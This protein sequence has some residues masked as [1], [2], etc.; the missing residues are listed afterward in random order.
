MAKGTPSRDHRR[1]V[2]RLQDHEIRSAGPDFATSQ[3]LIPEIM[4]Q[5]TAMLAPSL[6][7]LFEALATPAAIL[8]ADPVKIDQ[9][10]SG[11]ADHRR[12]SDL[13]TRVMPPSTARDT[14]MPTKRSRV[15]L[16]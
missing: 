12:K 4:P 15:L 8:N 2:A 5:P 11:R 10:T 9:N 7:S 1:S 3:A 14:P 16:P 13:G 6:R